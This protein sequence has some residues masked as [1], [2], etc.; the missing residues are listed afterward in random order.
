MPLPWGADRARRPTPTIRTGHRGG[1]PVVPQVELSDRQDRAS[2]TGGGER[3]RAGA[4]RA[5]SWP[6]GAGGGVVDRDADGAEVAAE[7]L[8]SGLGLAADVAVEA[9]VAR[10]RERLTEERFGPIDLLVSNA[11]IG[12]MAGIEAPDDVWQGIWDVNLMAHVYAA[13]AMIPRMLARARATSST[14]SA[15]G[16]LTN[17]G[18]AP[19]CVTKHAAVALAEWLTI[20]YGDDG[21]PGLLPLP[22][23][24]NTD[25]LRAGRPQP[26][27]PGPVVRAEA[28]P[29]LLSPEDVAE[30]VVAGWPRSAS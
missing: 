18:D 9:D 21:H 1:E 30:A 24:V 23:G 25:M 20:T 16:L 13:R 29:G 14:A 19:Y 11:G 7:P 26:S 8:A 28:Q 17:I 2:C 10:R 4:V 3:D 27:R 15:A 5:A 12:T 6:R 22:Q